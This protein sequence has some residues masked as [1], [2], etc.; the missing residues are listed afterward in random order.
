MS[1]KIL[2]TL[3]ILGFVLGGW[4]LVGGNQSA[5]VP[6]ITGPLGGVT[7][8]DIVDTSDGYRIDGTDVISGTGTIKSAGTRGTCY[9]F[10]YAA[11][12]VASSTAK[13]DCQGTSNWSVSGPSALSGIT[14]GD[15]VVA[16]LSTTTS[17]TI[18][19]GIFISG[20]SASTTSGYI[21]LSITNLTGG[22]F[23]WPQTGTASGT[24]SFIVIDN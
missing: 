5:P 24:A 18:N 16:T 22:T 15:A 21:Q 7:N 3:A 14:F 20:A 12:I 11:T 13:V 23:T 4:A 1:N 10:P 19:G 2:W 17:G 9:L 6:V 8:Y